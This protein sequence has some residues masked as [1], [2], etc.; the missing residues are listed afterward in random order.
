MWDSQEAFDEFLTHLRPVMDELG[1]ELAQPPEN[2]ADCGPCP[3]VTAEAIE[4]RVPRS[5]VMPISHLG[6]HAVPALD[7][8]SDASLCVIPASA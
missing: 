1:I 5:A 4:D 8:T 3:T 6:R 2:H 7:P